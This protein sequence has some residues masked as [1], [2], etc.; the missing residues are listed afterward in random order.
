MWFDV[1]KSVLAI[2]KLGQFIFSSQQLIP[3]IQNLV[4][5]AKQSDICPVPPSIATQR[6]LI[7]ENETP[8]NAN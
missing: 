6:L 3:K 4:T 1:S 2:S 7:N 5:N 8:S